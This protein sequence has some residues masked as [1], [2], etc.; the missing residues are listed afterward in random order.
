MPAI[1]AS[2]NKKVPVGAE[3]ISLNGRA[4]ADFLEFR[5]YNDPDAQRRLLIGHGG[6]R[7]EIVIKA[8]EPLDLKLAD[9]VYKHCRN[10]CDF[11]FVNG[12]PP[13]LRRELYFKDDDY[14]LSFL[15]GN[16]LSLTNLTA[17][18]MARIARLRLSPLYISVH[19]TS[20]AV[21][22]R[23]FNHE[24]AGLIMDQLRTL[25]DRGIT[26]H[27][28]IV[29]RPGIN[30]A[31]VLVRSLKDLTALY[32]GV[33]SVGVVP[34]GAS[35]HIHGVHL[36]GR[37][38]AAAILA[39]TKL[40]H[41][42]CRRRFG[43]GVVYASDELFIKA[44]SSIPP[45]DYYDDFP[46]YENGVGMVRRFLDGMDRLTVRLGRSG[47]FLFL[48][49]ELAYPYV[50]MLGQQITRRAKSPRTAIDVRA[51]RN[52]FFGRSVTVSG[53]LAG[54]DLQA[55]IA[56]SGRTY[57]RIVLPPDCV[58]DRGDFLD[59]YRIHDRR[60]LIAPT[61]LEELLRCLR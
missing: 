40:F 19:C 9:P 55:R 50:R 37:R 23:I 36:M 15:F 27:C 56:R 16:F 3:L 57:D 25:I 7:R 14:R 21:R 5:F 58:N 46:Q 4:I 35:R 51:V 43:A 29:V 6:R 33:A 17:A 34:V 52:R 10:T 24:R 60:V 53:L 30:D 22:N 13:G 42:R 49:G 59:G 47:R 26:L 20:P 41:D 38:L 8:R 1:L 2:N 12:L 11:C 54:Q 28:Q 39:Q 48:T 32:P 45:S 31:T 61:S 18:D 44:A